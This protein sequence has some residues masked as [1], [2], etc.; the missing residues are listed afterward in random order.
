M[1][2]E[3]VFNYQASSKPTATS[4]SPPT[5]N[6]DSYFFIV[7]DYWLL[8]PSALYYSWI[9]GFNAPAW[10]NFQYWL[11][12]KPYFLCNLHSWLDL[13][14]LTH[15]EFVAL[16]NKSIPCLICV[17]ISQCV[18]DC[19]CVFFFLTSPCVPEVW[20]IRRWSSGPHRDWGVLQGAAATARAGCRVQT[21]FQ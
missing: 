1:S 18:F 14:C 2:S 19:W 8:C 7:E 16:P 5:T 12:R 3:S 15:W 4:L 17:Y 13:L 20:P 10:C 9:V 21:L 11:L 6:Q